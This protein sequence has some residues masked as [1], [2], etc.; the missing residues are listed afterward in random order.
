MPDST[1]IFKPGFRVTDEN[2]TP[3]SGATL[4]FY[5]AGTSNSR[6]VYT[7]SSLST[8]AGSTVTCDAGG[9][10]AVSDVKILLYTGTTAYKV[11]AKTSAAVEL[12]SHDN[13]VGALD[14]SS[15]LTGSVVTT[16]PV[17]ASSSDVTIDADDKGKLYDIDCSGATVFVTLMSAVTAGD[18]FR[19]GFRHNGSA[20]SV[21]IQSVSNQEISAPGATNTTRKT[22]TLL[23]HGEVAWLASNGATWV[24]TDYV[25]PFMSRDVPI[26]RIAD[27]RTSPPVTPVV[28][29]RYIVN[30]TPTGTWSFYSEDDIIEYDGLS[31]YIQYTPT[32]DCGW[33]AYII[34]ED[35]N[36]QYQGSGWIDFNNVNQEYRVLHVQEQQSSGTAGGTFTF[37]AWRTRSLNTVIKNTITGASLASNQITLPLGSYT[38]R[39]T[40]A[41]HRVQQHQLRIR[42]ISDSSSDILGL[43]V[44]SDNATNSDV[45]GILNGT[46]VLTEEK[47]FELQH[48]A[49]STQATNG[50]GV[51][52]SFG[53]QEVYAD[54][55][56]TQIK[57]V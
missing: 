11:V 34:D 14:T 4:E 39:A 56:I 23:S 21:A 35:L 30:G 12:W 44:S 55:L 50:F 41:T 51:P 10:P 32:S 49:D 57:D 53:E 33:L 26:I 38:V 37:G 29:E 3:Q 8:S 54:I 25:P 22:L 5:D 52:T 36:T 24:V 46:L 15:F 1:L 47:V 19:I 16:S 18:G 31:G 27:R 43:V 7:D 20:N 40:G 45:P 48:R 28:G 9:Y 2:G 17:V 42:N 6:A 13:I